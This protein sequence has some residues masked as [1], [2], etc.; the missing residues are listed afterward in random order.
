MLEISSVVSEFVD[1]KIKERGLDEA[2]YVTQLA[3]FHSNYCP[4]KIRPLTYKLHPGLTSKEDKRSFAYVTISWQDKRGGLHH[5]REKWVKDTAA[6]CT[7]VAGL[8]TPERENA[9]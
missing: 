6:W 4:I 9:D 7:R 3:R 5:F 1:P 2:V 8:V